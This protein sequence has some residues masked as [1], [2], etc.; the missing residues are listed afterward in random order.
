MEEK[1]NIYPVIKTEEEDVEELLQI[2][3]KK[4]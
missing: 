2:K 4:V 3:L 1:E